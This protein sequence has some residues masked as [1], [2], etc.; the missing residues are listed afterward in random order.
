MHYLFFKHAL[1]KNFIS[2]NDIVWFL[3]IAAFQLFAVAYL[4]R[5][6]SR[7][8]FI[9]VFLFI[10]SGDYLAWVHN[11]MRQF[12]AVSIVL[13]SFRYIIE[14]Q[15]IKAVIVI[16]IASCLHGSALIML[17]LIFVVQGKAWNLRT[18][19]MIISAIIAVLFIDKTTSLLET[20]L[21]NTQ[22]EGLINNY[23]WEADNGTS[24]F[25][26]I[27]YSIPAVL[28]ILGKRYV[29]AEKDTILNISINCSIVSAALYWL[30]VFTSG[31][32]IGRLPIYVSLWGYIAIPAVIE[33]MFTEQSSK[34]VYMSMGILYVIYFYYQLIAWG[35]T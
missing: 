28:S 14:K 32:Y 2:H 18:V 25:R 34:L 24:M 23:I 3:L 19:L 22:Y 26:A 13:F 31:I 7:N 4:Y 21:V 6:Y 1:V 29:D 10:A 16:L 33:S 8:F 5:A 20:V 30:S 12:L 9:S 27:V 35:L 17:P 15:Y 11:G